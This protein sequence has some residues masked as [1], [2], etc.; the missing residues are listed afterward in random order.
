MQLLESESEEIGRISRLI[1]RQGAERPI[2]P[3]RRLLFRKSFNLFFYSVLAARNYLWL[4]QQ[5]FNDRLPFRTAC[6]ALLCRNSIAYRPHFLYSRSRPVTSIGA[7]LKRSG[8]WTSEKEAIVF[9]HPR[10]Q[11]RNHNP[12]LLFLVFLLS[13]FVP[14]LLPSPFFVRSFLHTMRRSSAL[15]CSLGREPYPQTFACSSS[16][17]PSSSSTSSGVSISVGEFIDQDNNE[18]GSWNSR[19][20]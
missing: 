7:F 18:S 15:P 2:D 6:K 10:L 16:P 17:P 9:L 19:N 11:Q 4:Q 1:W 5:L 20:S 13:P 14:M 8:N 3:G 12:S